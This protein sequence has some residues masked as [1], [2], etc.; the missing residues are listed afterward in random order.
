[1][2]NSPLTGSLDL[3]ERKAEQI[4]WKAMTSK[5]THKIVDWKIP[6]KPSTN[7]KILF[8]QFLRDAFRRVAQE[9]VVFTSNFKNSI[10]SNSLPADDCDPFQ[11]SS[12]KK[13]SSPTSGGV[14]DPFFKI[15]VQ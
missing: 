9:K 15:K 13:P 4:K 3:S 12:S 7:P 2:K 14:Y 6:K 5:K 1:M 8:I 11:P 10:F